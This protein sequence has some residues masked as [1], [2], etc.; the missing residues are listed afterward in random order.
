[1]SRLPAFAAAIAALICLSGDLRA[2]AVS[3]DK[4]SFKKTVLDTTFRSEGVAV[5]DFNKDGKNDIAAGSVWYRSARLEDA[6]DR[7]EGPGVRSA[8]L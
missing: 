7:R 4:I 3:G 8:W 2:Q 5:G 1:M 6:H